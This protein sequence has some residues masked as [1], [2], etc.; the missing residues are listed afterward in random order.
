MT[1]IKIH[2]SKERFCVSEDF[3]G[4]FFEDINRS[5]DGG[6]YPEMIRNRAFEDSV[7][8]ARVRMLNGTYGFQTPTGWRDQFNNGEGLQRW[9][10]DVEQTEIPG[11]YSRNAVMKLTDKECLNS[12]RLCALEVVYQKHGYIYNA[13]FR[14]ISIKKKAAYHFYMFAKTKGR[15]KLRISLV[16]RDDK[17]Y[18]SEEMEIKSDRYTK[19]EAGFY[20]EAD[21]REAVIK[22]EALTEGDLTIG[23]TSLMPV[24]TYKGHGMN[25][26]IMKMLKA[27]NS[28]FFR[29]PGGCIVEGFTKETAMRFSSTIGPVWERPSQ[30]L[31]W[32]YRN[33]N[34]LGFHEYLQ[35]CEDLDLEALYV[36]N[37]G[38]TCQ[39]RK[40]EFFEGKELE[41][42][43]QEALAALEY[44]MGPADSFWGKRR[45]QAG[46]PKPFTIKY[47][48]IG[49]EN[50]GEEYRK[51]YLLF[52]NKIKEKYPDI[53]LISNIH[54]EEVGLKTEMV[55]EHL[56]STASAFVTAGKVYD[57][58][59]RPGPGIFVGEYAVTSGPDVGNLRSA[60]AEAMY[61]IDLE[62]NQDVV[63][64]TA[65]APLIQNIHYTSWEPD[66]IVYDGTEAYGIPFYHAVC[67]MAGKRGKK[68]VESQVDGKTDIPHYRGL[69]G[70]VVYKNDVKIKNIFV[71]GRNEDVSHCILG[72]LKTKDKDIFLSV[73]DYLDEFKGHPNMGY[74]PPNTTFVT[75]GNDECAEGI[76]EA[77]VFVDSEDMVIDVCVWCHS[78]DMVFSRDETK[79]FSGK[80]NAVYTDRCI[81]RISD[82]EGSFAVVNRFNNTEFGER[83]K[84]PVRYGEYNRFKVIT[85]DG[86][87]ECYLNG[88]LVQK[89][90][91][92]SYPV[93]S[94]VAT[95]DDEYLYIKLLNYSLDDE[96]VEIELD[97]DVESVFEEE[98]LQDADEKAKNSFSEPE[99]IIPV[100]KN[101][102]GAERKFFYNSLKNS[103]NIL[104]IKKRK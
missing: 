71:N 3:Y 12:K 8:P 73:S 48:E 26:I 101:L 4:L 75:F 104:K 45:A 87:M 38:M 16:S 82:S 42:M 74:V 6:L 21:D 43:L 44:A 86:S 77:D 93:I 23:F 100:R 54:S 65:Y 69:Y 67:M 99:R 89:A 13:G 92:A 9:L 55:D 22:L 61:L 95:V 79:P 15:I 52:Y 29:F 50:V 19:Y 28:K 17:I 53:I 31:M 2:T 62:K 1:K 40:P 76:F 88:E 20:T 51:R 34:G 97:C 39:G 10:D 84:L 5:G 80:W 41:E 18:S 47:V 56:Y 94:A 24:D 63:K 46:H 102:Y 35:I 85:Y 78:C 32:H 30:M 64:L 36:V 81:W 60:L 72:E 7:P 83:R 59:S 49:N 98:T 68:V 25:P 11:W 103:L 90:G 70:L 58:Y 27:T 91:L 66:L 96:M 37:C 33:T 14:G 57:G